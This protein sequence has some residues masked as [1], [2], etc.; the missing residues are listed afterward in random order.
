[1]PLTE[2]ELLDDDDLDL[3][4]DDDLDLLDEPGERNG[5]RRSSADARGRVRAAGEAVR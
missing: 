3:L 2:A 1:V 4:D 5:S